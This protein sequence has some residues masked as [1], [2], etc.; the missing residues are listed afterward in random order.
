MS[1][2]KRADVVF[3]IDAS[4][5]MKPCFEELKKNIKK[6]VKPF[7]EEGFESLRLGLLAYNAG[8]G[9]E[10]WVYR[11]TFI[12][13]DAPENMNILYGEDEDA[14]ES[15]FTRSGD[16][17][18]DVD[19][20]CD[21]LDQITCCAD[22]NT[23]LAMDI[24]GD[25]P[26][27]P[28]CSTRRIMI[29]FTDEKLE[30]GVMKNEA[31]GENCSVL[32]QVM[33]K[34]SNER[35]ISLYYFGPVCDGLKEISE[36]SR[37]VI[38][39]VKDYHKRAE[40]ENIWA[41]MDFEK[42]LEGMGRNISQSVLQQV[43]ENE[44]H[45]AV[46]GQDQWDLES[47]G[48][49]ATGGIID[50]TD[51]KEGAVLDMSEPLEWINAQLH[52]TTPIDLDLHAFYIK[53]NG[54]QGHIMYNHKSADNLSLDMD[55]GVGNKFSFVDHNEENI[56]AT[57]L[58]GIQ[59]ILFATM[60]FAERGCFSDYNGKVVVTTSNT[61]QKPIEAKMISKQRKNWCVIAMLD[62]SNPEKPRVIPINH[63]MAN[64]P[65]VNEEIWVNWLNQ[66]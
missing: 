22:E 40:G 18:V 62:N 27:E 31:I 28:L 42:V 52:W 14:K 16:G 29:V 35:H 44:Y 6:F 11:N 19:T 25:F 30:D 38:Q 55:S 43:A 7:Q 8:P 4:D 46:Y 53:N 21:R 61:K 32:N 17:F 56:R 1:D 15:F 12:N 20:F 23:P 65:D 41:A 64:E 3:V 60:I 51:V 45:S 37:V 24:A 57:S 36:Y 58:N 66:N 10:K 48:R 34:I 26:F 9:D 59:R 50:I 2:A 47:W 5:S 39:E 63:V 33:D 49:Q 54:S 13:G